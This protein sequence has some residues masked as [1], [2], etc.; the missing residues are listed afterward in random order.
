MIAACASRQ[1]PFSEYLADGRVSNSWLKEMKRSPLHFITYPD[2][3]RKDTPALKIGRPIHTSVLEPE[4]F[5][6]SIVS[7]HGGFTQ[8]GK[9]SKSKGLASYKLLAAKAKANDQ[10]IL[11]EDQVLQCH[12]MRKAVFDHPVA[13]GMIVGAKVE[14]SIFWTSR[15]GVNMKIRP[16]IWQPELF[17][18]LKSTEDASIETFWRSAL[19]FEYHVQGAIYQDGLKA[20]TGKTLPFH[21]I[22]VEKNAPFDVV[23][24]HVPDA[25]LDLGRSIYEQRLLR[26]HSCRHNGKWPGA[27][28][29]GIATLEYPSYV[30]T[31]HMDAAVDWSGIEVVG[32]QD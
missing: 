30:F 16:D 12:S 9:P 3:P 22:A 19:K 26:G 18:D 23:V 21:I 28:P 4:R 24:Y 8:S 32:E 31:E 1:I 7:W 13:R 6:S 5:D 20:L 25:L 27:M 14:R 2:R 17:A 11:D 15:I 29:N 10:E